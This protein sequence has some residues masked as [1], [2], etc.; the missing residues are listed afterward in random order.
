MGVSSSQGRRGVAPSQ[1]EVRSPGVMWHDVECGPYRA[2]LALWRELADAETRR[3][4]GAILD[5]GAGT[6]RVALDLLRADHRVTAVDTDREL[7]LAL[8]ERA[9][10]MALETVCADART[11]DA[12]RGDFALCIA[13]MQTVQL[14]GGSSERVAFLRR[15]RAHLR[16]GGL[17]AC[18]IVTDLEQFDCAAGDAG[19]EEDVGRFA[20]DLYVSRAIRVR[21][22][23]ASILIVRERRVVR[24][25]HREAQLPAERDV[26]EL[27]R[28]S[29]SQLEREGREAGLRSVEART[30]GPTDE[31]LGSVVVML[32]A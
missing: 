20:G 22:R 15:A 7:L 29:R 25:G 27:A 8:G 24:Q 32:R 1:A 11:F 9:A 19:P 16:P 6:G 31:H 17:L 26:V 21:A 28:V 2:D 13:A 23:I 10:G 12:G 4:P 18:A 3:Q 30:V 14:L 5:V